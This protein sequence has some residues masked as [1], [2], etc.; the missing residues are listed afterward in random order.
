MSLVRNILLWSS[1]NY[2]IS[3][4]LPKYKFVQKSVSRFMPGEK[5]D[6]ALS[7]SYELENMGYGTIITYLGE[8]SLSKALTLKT[9]NQYQDALEDIDERSLKT[10]ISVKLTQL[11]L[12]ID[13]ELCFD[14]LKQLLK[15]AELKNTFV[16][17]DMEEYIYLELTLK[18]YKKLIQEHQNIGITL[19]SY[20]YRSE[21]DLKSL[22]EIAPYI[23]LV[24]GAYSED[25]SVSMQ[26]RNEIDGNYLKLANLML[27]KKILKNGLIPSFA[28]HDHHII[29]SLINNI[30]A[31]EIEKYHYEFNML[32]GI[33]RDLQNEILKSGQNLKILISYGEEWFPWYVRRLAENPKNLFLLLK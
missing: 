28:T 10:V 11:G 2:W 23:R 33:R 27:E 25:S 18:I 24:K 12:D 21:D 6:D 20:L 17:I 19:Q 1:K 29:Y 3:H 31:A 9:V 14:N 22:L 5:L 16:W 4:K 8:N 26:N 15:E 13:E 30:N 7:K 32:Y